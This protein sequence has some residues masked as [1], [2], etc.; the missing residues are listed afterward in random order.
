MS[1]DADE[2]VQAVVRFVFEKFDEVI[3]Q[4]VMRTPEQLVPMFLQGCPTFIKVDYPYVGRYGQPVPEFCSRFFQLLE[5][6]TK[7]RMTV[8]PYSLRGLPLVD[9]TNGAYLCP[10]SF[11]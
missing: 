4:I 11:D 2:H 7:C 10:M 1:L 6:H 3:G 5:M 8:R 9:S